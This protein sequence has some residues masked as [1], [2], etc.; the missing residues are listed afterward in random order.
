MQKS[1]SYLPMSAVMPALSKTKADHIKESSFWQFEQQYKASGF[2]MI[3]SL[4]FSGIAI[5]CSGKQK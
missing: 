2:S 5:L 3:T 4:D 1:H